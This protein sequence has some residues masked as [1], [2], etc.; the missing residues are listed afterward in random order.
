MLQVR[1]PIGKFILLFNQEP[2]L[3]KDGLLKEKLENLIDIIKYRT[4]KKGLSYTSSTIQDDLFEIRVM[5][6]DY[7]YNSPEILAEY[8]SKIVKEIG[9]KFFYQKHKA[10][11]KAVSDTLEVYLQMFSGLSAIAGKD[12]HR[13]EKPTDIPSL[14]GLKLLQYLQPSKEFELLIKWIE[15]SL[16]YDYFLIVAELFFNDEIV[17]SETPMVLKENIVHSFIE[18]GAYSIIT[19]FW[20]PAPDEQNQM[21]RN[22]IIRSAAIECEMG[23]G[24]PINEESLYQL[25]HS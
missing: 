24:I 22:I 8:E 2:V 19:E 4:Q 15:S 6:L 10:L 20:Q 9:E 17:L 18:F 7:L 21:I 23:M 5:L 12:F 1:S 14:S 11:G 3:V 16:Q 25:L 13:P